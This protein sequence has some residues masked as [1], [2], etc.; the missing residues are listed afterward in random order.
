MSM[1]SPHISNE[2]L[3]AVLLSTIQLT[4]DEDAHIAG[5]KCPKCRAA[6]LEVGLKHLE[7]PNKP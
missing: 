5:W 7:R 6:M 1:D 4:E 2:R 3:E